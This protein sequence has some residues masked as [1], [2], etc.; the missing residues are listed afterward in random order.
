M[1][2]DQ[3]THLQSIHLQAFIR[4]KKEALYLQDTQNH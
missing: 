1:L 4:I 2:S 3:I